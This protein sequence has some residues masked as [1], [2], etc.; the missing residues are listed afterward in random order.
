MVNAIIHIT[1]TAILYCLQ[2]ENEKKKERAKSEQDKK[3][4]FAVTK[5]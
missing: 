4:S 5:E 3:Q 2:I 1:N